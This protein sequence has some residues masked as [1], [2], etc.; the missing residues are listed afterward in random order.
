MN[1]RRCNICDYVE[2][3]H[4]KECDTLHVW[5]NYFKTLAW[6]MGVSAVAACT[7]AGFAYL[8]R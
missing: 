5:R 3:Y 7:L 4:A 2:P 8:T 6:V 1:A